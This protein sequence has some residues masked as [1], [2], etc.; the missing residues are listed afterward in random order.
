M[1]AVYYVLSLKWSKRRDGLLTW[2]RPNNNGYCYRLEEA[3]RYT[4]EQI[5]AKRNYY[6][7]GENTRAIPCANVDAMAIRVGEYA[8]RALD[9]RDLEQ[10]VV[11]Y[12][13]LRTLTRPRLVRR[14][15][16]G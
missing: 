10:R 5:E 13:H 8:G 3:G 15:G 2:W 1:T 11:S 4:A 7:D 14:G 12:K 9:R 16:A 6:D